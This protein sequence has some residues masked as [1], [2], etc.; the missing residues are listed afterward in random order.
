MGAIIGG[1][2]SA[3]AANKARKFSS[4]EA[5]KNRAFQEHMSGTQYQRSMADMRKAGLNP[6]L[7]YAQGGAGNLSGATA[8]GVQA[9]VGGANQSNPVETAR[10]LKKTAVD[11]KN[12][13][14]SRALID[15]QKNK[16]D[17][18]ATVS[19]ASATEIAVRTKLLEDKLPKSDLMKDAWNIKSWGPKLKSTIQ[20][21]Q[22][23]YDAPWKELRGGSG[24]TRTRK[25]QNKKTR[26]GWK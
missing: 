3:V 26:G 5:A 6:M 23:D 18:D 21:L 20:Q 9:D 15:A 25:A 17:M 12:L 13:N 22:V 14:S 19:A 10:G 16:T 2:A 1:I 7:A 8:S 11:I 24:M 4:R